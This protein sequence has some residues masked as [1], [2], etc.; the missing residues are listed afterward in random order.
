MTTYIL[1]VIG[2]VKVA[3]I[4]IEK[5]CPGY[6]DNAL[7][8]LAVCMEA[9][10]TFLFQTYLEQTKMK[11]TRNYQGMNLNKIT[12]TV[13]L[14]SKGSFLSSGI[15]VIVMYRPI[16]VVLCMYIGLSFH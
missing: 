16:G 6:L 10:M 8:F 1:K 11:F 13:G 5:V 15:Q 14:N 2:V 3:D 7:T 9:V 4:Q 12:T